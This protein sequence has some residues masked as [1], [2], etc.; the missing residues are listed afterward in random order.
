MGL[1]VVSFGLFGLASLYIIFTIESE[2]E[3]AWRYISGFGFG[4][5][6]IALFARVGGGVYTKAADVG[7]D[8]LAEQFPFVA[9]ELH[10]LQLADRGEIIR[11][12]GGFSAAGTV[13]SSGLSSAFEHAVITEAA[14]TKAHCEVI[15]QSVIRILL[16]QR[17]KVPNSMDY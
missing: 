13:V 1:T 16:H 5:S 7:A 9:L 11:G 4:A 8:D 12:D 2:P 10:Q 17:Q 3:Q 15:F 14:I 6:A